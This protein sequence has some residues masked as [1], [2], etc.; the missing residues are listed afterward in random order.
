[1]LP[2]RSTTAAASVSLPSAVAATVRIALTSSAVRICAV[3]PARSD[4]V[5]WEKRTAAAPA[6]RAAVARHPLG[7]TPG[8]YLLARLPRPESLGV[9]QAESGA[10]ACL[11]IP[12]IAEPAVGPGVC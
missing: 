8:F 4:G 7:R 9:A 12:P 5:F 3:P 1:M 10:I 2:V 11:V 6:I